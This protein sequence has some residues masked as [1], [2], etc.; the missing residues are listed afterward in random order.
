MKVAEVDTQ[1]VQREAQDE[2]APLTGR[3]GGQRGYDA[4]D[5]SSPRK[6]PPAPTGP[7]N[8]FWAGALLLAL[9]FV[10]VLASSSGGGD[11]GDSATDSEQ[12]AQISAELDA[13]SATQEQLASGAGTGAGT[14][15]GTSG[16]AGG[17]TGG[18]AYP[19]QSSADELAAIRGQLD[20]ISAQLSGPSAAGTVTMPAGH[21]RFCAYGADQPPAFSD[22]SDRAQLRLPSAMVPKHYHWTLEPGTGYDDVNVQSF[23]GSVE[24][25]VSMAGGEAPSSC[26]P[27]RAHPETIAISSVEVM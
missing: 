27:M 3:T 4:L 19:A 21:D 13:I 23:A 20:T 1:G 26:I 2:E 22:R 14:G 18:G 17:G 11:G 5:G 10:I 9:G 12:L 15:G 8:W 7:P 16:G 6:G 25:T 24:L